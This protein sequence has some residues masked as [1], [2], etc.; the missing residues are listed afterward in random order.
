[1]NFKLFW[2]ICTSLA[3]FRRSGS[4][5]WREVRERQKKGGEERERGGNFRSYSLPHPLAVFPA[6]ISCHR[7]NNLNAWDRIVRVKQRI[8]L[9]AQAIKIDLIAQVRYNFIY[10]SNMTPRL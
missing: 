3:F 10:N 7:P 2:A 9:V 4:G 1:M 8:F 5:V 6:P